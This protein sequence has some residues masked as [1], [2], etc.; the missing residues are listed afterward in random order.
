MQD[1]MEVSGRLEA[2]E[3]E[4]ERAELEADSERLRVLEEVYGSLD[5]ELERDVE[6]TSSPRR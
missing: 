3:G 5:A 1:D 4:L 2:L 6:Q